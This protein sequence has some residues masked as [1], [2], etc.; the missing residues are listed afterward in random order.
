MAF[1][2]CNDTVYTR[3]EQP[4]G[5]TF[6]PQAFGKKTPQRRQS[7]LRRRSRFLNIRKLSHESAAASQK[8]SPEERQTRDHFVV[9]VKPGNV[10]E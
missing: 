3:A 4:A 6:R 9:P 8:E 5:S 10:E 1:T 7:S 2:H